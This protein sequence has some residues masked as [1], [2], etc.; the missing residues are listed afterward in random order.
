MCADLQRPA[1]SSPMLARSTHR[2]PRHVDM[3]TQTREQKQ[4]ESRSS[5]RAEAAREQKQQESRSRRSAG[6]RQTHAGSLRNLRGVSRIR[7]E[8]VSMWMR[9]C[10]K[11]MNSAHSASCHVTAGDPSPKAGLFSMNPRTSRYTSLRYSVTSA[12]CRTHLRLIRCH[13][14]H[15][16]AIPR[17][18]SLPLICMAQRVAKSIPASLVVA[19]LHGRLC[20]SFADD[21]SAINNEEFFAAIARTQVCILSSSQL[22][23]TTVLVLGACFR[24]F[25]SCSPLTLSAASVLGLPVQFVRSMSDLASHARNARDA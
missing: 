18:V 4:Q 7:T 25:P 1:T 2:R 9:S 8:L 11:A 20:C 6:Q 14:S 13:L 21:L 24:L 16:Q 10:S 3:W 15:L 22:Q 19:G 5:K 23:G 12:T 17:P